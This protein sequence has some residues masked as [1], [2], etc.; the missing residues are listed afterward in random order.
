[1][2][3]K[4]ET[5]TQC[6]R[7]KRRKQQFEIKHDEPMIISTNNTREVTDSFTN[8]LQNVMSPPQQRPETQ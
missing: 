3:K 5:E 8:V 1:M 7:R 6:N 2:E 4:T